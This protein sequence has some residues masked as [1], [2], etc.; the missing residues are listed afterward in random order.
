MQREEIEGFKDLEEL[1]LDLVWS[2]DHRADR[3][4]K[5][6]DPDLWLL[7]RNPLIVLQTVSNEKLKQVLADPQYRKY[8]DELKAIDEALHSQ[9]SGWFQ[10]KFPKTSLTT[11]AYFSMEFML[12]EN[13]PIYS[14]GLGN[15]AGDQLKAMN[16]LGVPVVGVGLLYQQG[17]FRQLIDKEGAQQAVYPYNSPNQL[18]VRPV[19]LPNGEW[20][21]V[22][23][24]MPG[25]KLWLRAWEVKVGRVMLYLLDSNDTANFPPHRAITSELYG[26]NAE[27]RLKQEIVLG[28]GGW[29]LLKAMGIQPE[30][31][32]LNE[33]HAAFAILERAK[34]FKE[35]NG[36]SFDVALTAIRAGNLFTTHTA[37]AAGFDRFDPYFINEYLGDYALKHLGITLDELLALGR[38]NPKDGAEPFSTAYLA[39]RG[40]N[41]VNGVS[42]LHGRVSRHLFAR[43]F[44]RWPIAE[45]PVGH[46]TNGVHVRS[47]GSARADELW[48]LTCDK[49]C[50]LGEMETMGEKIRQ[51]PDERIWKMRND[52]R[53]DMI[54]AGRT[55]L[56]RVFEVRGEPV[57]EVERARHF[58]D[59]DTLTIGFARRFA[60]YKRPN[61]L[62]QN[63]DRFIRI[64]TNK[65]RPVQLILA[66][67]AHPA[68]K[69]G[70][71]LI[72]EWMQFINRAEVRPHVAFI[73][74]YDV[75]VTERL[76]GGVDLWINTPRRPW[77]A[78][79]T[80]GMKVLV[81]G[82]LNVSELDGWWAEAYSPE[83]GWALGDGNEH[84]DDP[85]WDVKDANQLYDLLESE[86]IPEFYNR[87]KDD[88]PRAWVA[89]IKESMGRLTPR[90]SA[91]RAVFDYAERYY[92]PGA[93]SYLQRAHDKGKRAKEIVRWKEEIQKHWP[94]VRFA[95]IKREAQGKEYVFEAKVYL[96]GLSE[97]AVKVELFADSPLERFEMKRVKA[98]DDRTFLYT[99]KIPTTRPMR[100]F[101]P[102]ILPYFEGVPMALEV[103][104]IL[105]EGP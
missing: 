19:R 34:D 62:L 42:E 26:G 6:L 14:G 102:R 95:E 2:W 27:M 1:A 80:S 29:R 65:D 70:Q 53:K 59:V 82:G 15:V 60:T 33:G 31:C 28:I 57:E 48:T 52:A 3:I 67:K 72:R 93:E 35:D 20:L 64:L 89:K 37:V 41:A 56:A 51:T 7:T 16:D 54:E 32:H 85:V 18:P 92:L 43:L 101:T 13:L 22:E 105:W 63:P 73:P 23:I 44:P 21:R 11:V 83:V 68:D 5:G 25:W 66:G 79:G 74:D 38:E 45:V 39:I 49:E 103:Q 58:F 40:S 12:S 61:I 36:V 99:V 4:W 69:A 97:N 9:K 50:W 96:D 77:E 91:N 24:A 90:F 88:I 10:R 47:W 86:I 8:I 81:N 100:E 71:D 78:C 104:Q 75:Q 46:V 76:V 94:S 87:D 55:R 17:Y 30:V 84:D 98:L